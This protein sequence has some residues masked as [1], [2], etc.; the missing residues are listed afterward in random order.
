MYGAD[1][2]VKAYSALGVQLI[3]GT[4]VLTANLPERSVNQVP[5]LLEINTAT[6]PVE[7]HAGRGYIMLTGSAN[8]KAASEALYNDDRLLNN[9]ALVASSEDYAWQTSFW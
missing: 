6:Q 2:I 4:L 7:V 3:P 5:Q 8:Y 1:A 9:P